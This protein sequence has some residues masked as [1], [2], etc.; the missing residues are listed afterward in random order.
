M[1]GFYLVRE[2][3][4]LGD[5]VT[6]FF[7]LEDK[8]ILYN[9]TARLTVVRSRCEN[10]LKLILE[11]ESIK[12]SIKVSEVNLLIGLNSWRES[13]LEKEFIL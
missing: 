12:V 8:I 10:F 6:I 1:A 9:L 3:G 13:K 4:L 2:N 5:T 7:H 11:I